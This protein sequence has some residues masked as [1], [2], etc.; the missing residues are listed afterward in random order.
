MKTEIKTVLITQKTRL[1]NLIQ[2]YNTFGQAKFYIEHHEGDFSDYQ[3]EHETYRKTVDSAAEYLQ[4]LGR[5][6][7]LDRDNIA[8]YIFGANDTVVAVGRDGLIANTLKYLVSQALIGVNPDPLRWDGCLLPFCVEDLPKIVPEAVKGCRPVQSVTMAQAT[9]NDGQI[10]YSVNDLF[11]GQKTHASAR[12][13]LIQGNEREKQS[14]SGI[15]VSTGLGSTGWLRSI[16]AGA[17]GIARYCAGTKSF[18]L[19]EKLDKSSQALYYTVREP[20]PGISTGAD[21]VFGRIDRDTPL[22]IV[23]AMPENGVIFSDGIEEDF[24]QFNSGASAEIGISDRR[25]YLIT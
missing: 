6:H 7:I 4:S 23:S 22:R 19:P 14:S 17:C 11:I 12:Y 1:E 8:N 13:E 5:L 21:M 3:N 25:G 18:H 16:L 20:Y 15:I 24:L 9:L 2:R 10:L